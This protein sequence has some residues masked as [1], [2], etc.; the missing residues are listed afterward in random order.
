MTSLSVWCGINSMKT[1]A[2]MALILALAASCA[3]NAQNCAGGQR[4]ILPGG[5]YQNPTG[6]DA[7]AQS[8]T[9]KT[10]VVPM[11][12]GWWRDELVGKNGKP[13][14]DSA[15]ESCRHSSDWHTFALE[16]GEEAS[17]GCGKTKLISRMWGKP[18]VLQVGTQETCRDG[19]NK[20][21]TTQWLVRLDTPNTPDAP[22]RKYSL[23]TSTTTQRT[24]A[25]GYV[26]SKELGE[27]SRHTWLGACPTGTHNGQKQ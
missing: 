6:K 21:T 15:Y 25:P 17:E 7:Q 12:A 23:Y 22:L 8:A 16:A 4:S 19:S 1:C 14:P 11:Q 27:T 13:V 9:P 2:H 3:A 5:C 24:P 18:P 26:Q 20:V 10:Q